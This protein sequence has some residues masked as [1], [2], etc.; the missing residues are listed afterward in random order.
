MTNDSSKA[1]EIA[2]AAL[3]RLEENKLIEGT[4]GIWE[5]I[6]RI[7]RAMEIPG[8]TAAHLDRTGQMTEQQM[9]KRIESAIQ[10]A[11]LI[12]WRHKVL[13]PAVF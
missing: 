10:A 5:I 13:R 11:E 1:L 2:Q 7:H 12:N 4:F 8:I 3:E 6:C 9:L